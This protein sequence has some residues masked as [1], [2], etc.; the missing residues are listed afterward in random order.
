[1]PLLTPWR[2][3]ITLIVGKC[4]AATQSE[5]ALSIIWLRPTLKRP[6]KSTTWVVPIWFLNH[7]YRSIDLST[8]LSVYLSVCLSISLS[9]YLSICLSIDLSVY[10]SIH[11][12]IYASIHLSAN[13]QIDR[14]MDKDMDI[15]KDINPLEP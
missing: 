7:V 10:L 11:P 12:S 5:G 9:V 8:Y 15:S 2:L 13:E 4:V 14:K 3:A 1:M 6:R